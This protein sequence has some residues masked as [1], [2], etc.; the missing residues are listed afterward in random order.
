MFA[1]PADITETRDHFV[2]HLDLPGVSRDQVKVRLLGDT[3]T[4]SGERRREQETTNGG[5]HRS[6]RIHGTFERSFT[7]GVPVRN[8][9]IKATFK[10]GVLTI[11][12]PK[13][14]EAKVREIEIQ[15]TG[16]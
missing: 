10:D 6:E 5:L 9:G 16:S 7:L 13:A 3:L 12:V 11:E 14:E 2:V 1:P 4:V 15:T 8:E